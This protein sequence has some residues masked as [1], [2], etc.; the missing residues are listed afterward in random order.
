MHKI[1]IPE[2]VQQTA[3][4]KRGGKR[5][6][7]DPLVPQK[8]AL[9][10]IDMQLFFMPPG[11]ENNPPYARQIVPNINRLATNLRQAGGQVVWITSHFGPNISNEWSVLMKHIYAPERGKFI[12]DNLKPGGEGFPLWPELQTA[13]GD[14]HIEKDRFSA[15]TEGASDL[16]SRLREAQIDTVIVTGT[17]TNVC[18]ESTARDAT[19]RN[20][21]TLMISDANAASNDRDHNKSIS[22]LMGVFAD[23]MATDEL[24]DRL[25]GGQ[26]SHAQGATE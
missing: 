4:D 16:E 19:M 7:F 25:E 21:K 6:A 15:F 23:V 13:E 5:F 2:Q 11:D 24:V 17:L 18:C 10:V 26:V 20:F 9:L 3:R 1:E 12:A 14:W 8:M 22:G